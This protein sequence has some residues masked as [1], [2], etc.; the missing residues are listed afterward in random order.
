M[1]LDQVS[2]FS[3][4]EREKN[5]QRKRIACHSKTEQIR[6]VSFI[7]TVS[8]GQMDRTNLEKKEPNDVSHLMRE[9]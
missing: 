4:R 1:L 5:T 9:K 6:I 8:N 3:S 2:L 7:S